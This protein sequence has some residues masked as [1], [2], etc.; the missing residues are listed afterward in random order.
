MKYHVIVA[1]PPWKF[2]DRL[3]GKS[4]GAAKN[5]DV[6]TTREICRIALP[7]IAD[8]AYLFLWRVSSMVEEAY[9][10]VRMWGFVPKSEIVWEKVTAHGKPWFGMGRHVRAAHESCIVAVR[11]RPQPKARNVRSRFAAP[12]GVHSGK[13]EAFFELVERLAHGPYLEL[14]SRRQRENWTCLGNQM[15]TVTNLGGAAGVR[16]AG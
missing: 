5:Y 1:D 7:P 14:F 12:V 8:D 9:Q 4:R 2:G 13:P 3:P 15:P 16:G 10:V 11:G 6:M